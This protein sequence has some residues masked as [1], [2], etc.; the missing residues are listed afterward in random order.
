MTEPQAITAEYSDSARARRPGEVALDQAH[1][2][3]HHQRR[4]DALYQPE[5]DQ[6][7]GRGR[8]PAQQ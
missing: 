1:H 6:R 7:S 4:T 8:Q 3:R 5:R 2:L